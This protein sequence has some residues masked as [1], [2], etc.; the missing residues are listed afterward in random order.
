MWPSVSWNSPIKSVIKRQS[1]TNEKNRVHFACDLRF[2]GTHSP[3]P[4]FPL[5]LLIAVYISFS[6]CWMA[7]HHHHQSLNREGRWGTTDDFANSFLRGTC[8]TPGLSIPWCCLPTASSVYLVFF[9]LSLC[10]A[11]WIWPDLMNGK[12]DHTTALCAS[13]RLLGGL[14]VI[15]C[16]LELGKDFLVGNTVFVWDV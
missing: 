14:R 8:R 9:P 13:L 2:L 1:K 6:L 5:S 11:G 4:P 15:D 12:R 3:S 16:L 10:L 7:L